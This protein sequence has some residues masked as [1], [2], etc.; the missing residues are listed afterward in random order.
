[1]APSM[2]Q[3]RETMT[4]ERIVLRYRRTGQATLGGA[5]Q[6]RQGPQAIPL[7]LRSPHRRTALER[8]GQKPWLAARTSPRRYSIGREETAGAICAYEESTATSTGI[9]AAI[10]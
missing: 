3:A 7:R 2:V 8:R 4:A 6:T 9:R 5:G 10:S 1:M